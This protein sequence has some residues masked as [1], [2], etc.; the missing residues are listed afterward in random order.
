MKKEQI[1]K[2]IKKASKLV[3]NETYSKEFGSAGKGDIP[4]PTNKEK[5]DENYDRIFRKDKKKCQNKCKCKKDDK[6]RK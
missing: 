2:D 4:R 5:Y 1:I 6:P 3:S